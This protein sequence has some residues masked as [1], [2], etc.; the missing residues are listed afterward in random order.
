MLDLR[1]NCECC[2]DL[3]PDATDAPICSFKCTF[4]CELFRDEVGPTMPEPW[5][6]I[7]ATPDPS[8]RQVAN[9]S[10]VDQASP[11]VGAMLQNR[12]AER[13]V[14]TQERPSILAG[15]RRHC[16]HLLDAP[17]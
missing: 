5:R 6:R 11:S 12:V 10:G 9:V 14:F 4:C 3:P 17:L 2:K 7:P 13:R 8:G 16:T 15:R 1:P